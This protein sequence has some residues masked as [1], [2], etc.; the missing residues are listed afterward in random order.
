M[1]EVDLNALR[2]N[3]QQGVVQPA[4]QEPR[5]GPDGKIRAGTEEGVPIQ[6]AIFA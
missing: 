5:V 3:L 4:N 2:R 6:R 1:A